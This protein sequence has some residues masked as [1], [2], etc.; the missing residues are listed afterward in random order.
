MKYNI[1]ITHCYPNAFKVVSDAGK[2]DNAT[3]RF[4]KT[5]EEAKQQIKKNDGTLNKIIDGTKTNA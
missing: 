5:I 1:I 3:Y 4:H 2:N